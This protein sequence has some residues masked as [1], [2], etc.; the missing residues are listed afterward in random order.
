[1]ESVVGEGLFG[2][3]VKCL[4]LKDNK[5]V[6][7]KVLKNKRHCFTHIKKEVCASSFCFSL[8]L[9]EW[10]D[11]DAPRPLCPQLQALLTLKKVQPEKYN[12]VQ[13][14]TVF[15][16]RGHF[17]CVFEHLDTS[18]YD[19]MEENDFC[20]LPLAGIRTIVEQVLSA[21]TPTALALL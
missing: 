14:H 19:F 4:R 17:C 6:A 16:D 18:L 5:T 1:M 12:I 8:P 10:L 11:L 9:C 21:F 2:K 3:V 20:P 15:F 7:I 13:M